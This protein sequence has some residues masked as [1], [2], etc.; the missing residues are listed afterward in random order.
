MK[1]MILGLPTSTCPQLCQPQPRDTRG[2]S[3]GLEVPKKG[4]GHREVR[5]ISVTLDEQVGGMDSLPLDAV[6]T[7]GVGTSVLPADRCHRQ[8][9]IT[10]LGPRRDGAQHPLQG[11]ANTTLRK[12]WPRLRAPQG[13][14]GRCLTCHLPPAT[15]TPANLPAVSSSS[16]PLHGVT[17]HTQTAW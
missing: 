12:K 7:T 10:H 5:E 15:Q 11:P 6:R 17:G 14:A 4:P 9:P 1:N 13:Y 16:V 2:S 3:A 8:A